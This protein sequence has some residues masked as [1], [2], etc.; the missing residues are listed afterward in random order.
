MSFTSPWDCPCE[1]YHKLCEEFPD[2]SIELVAM[3]EA[4]DYY[5]E[6]GKL[7]KISEQFDEKEAKRAEVKRVFDE[8]DLSIDDYNIEKIIENYEDGYFEYLDMFDPDTWEFTIDEED[9]LDFC[10]QYKKK[11]PRKKK[12]KKQEV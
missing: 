5:W 12:A 7:G 8:H 6:N 1:W 4:M 3:D 2:V 11:K 10:K 9:F